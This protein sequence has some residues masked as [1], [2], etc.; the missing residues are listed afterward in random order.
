MAKKPEPTPFSVHHFQSKIIK[1][2]TETK[3]MNGEVKKYID[4]QKSPQKEICISLRKILLKALPE[5]KEEMK[6]GALVYDD[7]RYYIGVVRYGVNFGFAINGL[8]KKEV[9]LLEGSGKT[10]RHIKIEKLKDIDKKKLIEL[11]KLVK[12]KVVCNPC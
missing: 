12:K 2:N 1:N 3:N 8:D 9:A 10:M 6:W 7:G 11:I 4:K 5:I